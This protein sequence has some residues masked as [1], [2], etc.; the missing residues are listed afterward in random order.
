MATYKDPK[1]KN[2]FVSAAYRDITG[3]TVV[4]TKRGI[5]RA[6]KKSLSGPKYSLGAGE[7]NRTP[8]S[9][10]GRSRSTIGLHLQF[11]CS[12]ILT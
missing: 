10:L 6:R 3:K 11:Y 2:C 7:G 1:T 4:H 8:V 12:L 5:V 9:T